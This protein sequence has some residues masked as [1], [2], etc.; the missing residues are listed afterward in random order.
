[1]HIELNH[2]SLR[3]SALRV[4][5]P[6]R[7]ARI[8]ASIRVEGQKTPVLI[9]AGGTLVDGY[10]RV[11]AIGGL[12]LDQVSAV[13]LAVDEGEA[14]FLTWQMETGR[15]K[16]ALEEA[17]LLTE[18]LSWGASVTSLAQRLQ[19][20]KS[21]VSQRLGLAR[22]LPQSVQDA[23]RKCIIPPHAAMKCLLPM[24]RMDPTA[25][26]TMVAALPGA[27]SVRQVETLY[28]AWRRAD[29]EVRRRIETDPALFLKVGDA[30]KHPDDRLVSALEGITRGCHLSRKLVQEGLFARANTCQRAWQ[31]A[32]AAFASLEE[33]LAHDHG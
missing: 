11:A 17:W 21:W 9:V 3:F 22:T 19:R 10:H 16:S 12:A 8:A 7:V 18:L 31:Q 13:E 24:A 4:L 6:G 28:G 33:E 30:E 2:L 15:R 14:L 32:Q 26:A 29:P 1:M 25:C 20:T 27:V 5:E 23:V